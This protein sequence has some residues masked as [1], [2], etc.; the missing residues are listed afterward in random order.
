MIE[1]GAE[2]AVWEGLIRVVVFKHNLI[3][4]PYVARYRNFIF[5]T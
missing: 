5:T 1:N 4:S 2:A 3:D